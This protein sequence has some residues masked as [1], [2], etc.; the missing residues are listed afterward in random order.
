MSPCCIAAATAT[1]VMTALIVVGLTAFVLVTDGLGL[2]LLLGTTLAVALQRWTLI[3]PCPRLLLGL[4]ALLAA[5]AAWLLAT[6]R[7]SLVVA[8]WRLV[9][10]KASWAVLHLTPVGRLPCV[11]RHS[12]PSTAHPEGPPAIYGIGPRPGC[13]VER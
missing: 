3:G 2:G 11:H 12:R 10:P 1:A 5:R 4:S 13:R 7:R 9:R 8:V 6:T